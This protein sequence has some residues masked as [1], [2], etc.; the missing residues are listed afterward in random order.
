[1]LNAEYQGSWPCGFRGEDFQN[2][3]LLGAMV[4]S[5]NLKTKFNLSRMYELYIFSGYMPL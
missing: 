3:I 1:M 2:K 5:Y 4:T